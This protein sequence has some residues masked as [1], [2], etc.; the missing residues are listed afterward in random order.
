MK[1]SQCTAAAEAICQFC[2]RAVCAEH[3]QTKVFASGFGQINKD[4]LL[5]SSQDVGIVVDN[6]VWCGQCKIRYQKTY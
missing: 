4:A 6:A 1:C 2:G 5:I 3:T